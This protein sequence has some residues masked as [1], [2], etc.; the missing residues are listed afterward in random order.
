[1]ISN[2]M[3]HFNLF[4]CAIIVFILPSN[5]LNKQSRQHSLVEIHEFTGRAV[6]ILYIII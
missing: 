2:S 4:V 3:E 1:M 5:F 6:A